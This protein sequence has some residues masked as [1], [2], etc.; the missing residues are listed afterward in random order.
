[1]SI[2]QDDY[3]D[4]HIHTRANDGQWTPETLVKEAHR[5]GLRALA[6]TDHDTI[7]LVEETRREAAS[8]S[9]QVIP[10]VEVNV[11]W[12]QNL[13]HLLLYNV[14]L[15]DGRLRRMLDD[16]FARHIARATACRA[17]MARRGLTLPPEAGISPYGDLLPI[18]L[19][20]AVIKAGYATSFDSALDVLGDDEILNS[21]VPLAAAVEVAH[22]QGALAILAHPGRVDVPTPTVSP[23]MLLEMMDDAPL[24]GIEAHYCAYGP[25]ETELY[26]RFA[27]EHRLLVTCGSDSH[28][29]RDRRP[30]IKWPARSC[31]EFLKRCGLASG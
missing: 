16:L 3:V 24:D 22:A 25:A 8:H 18:L 17:D 10:G 29:P 14:N 23:A 2:H 21:A 31:W 26:N 27:T 15:Q 7:K 1:M 19:I 30:L 6:V 9:I 5:L 11:T 28:G 13:Y 4:L 20:D 12:R